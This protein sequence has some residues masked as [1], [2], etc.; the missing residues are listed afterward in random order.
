MIVLARTQTFLRYPG[1]CSSC[2][3]TTDSSHN[4]SLMSQNARK[5]L[6]YEKS[7]DSSYTIRSRSSQITETKNTYQSNSNSSVTKAR[8]VEYRFGCMCLISAV[9]YNLLAYFLIANLLTGVV[10]LCIETINASHMLAF[11]IMNVY[12]LLLHTV[13]T[14]FYRRKILLKL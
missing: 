6:H 14:V 4:P 7:N 2:S 9:N 3:S 11:V 1:G 10:N 13:V 12:L 5:D 8:T